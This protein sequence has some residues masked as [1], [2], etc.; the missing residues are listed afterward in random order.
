MSAFTEEERRY[1]LEEYENGTKIRVIAD[2]L[3][4]LYQTVRSAVHSKWYKEMKAEVGE[5][6]KQVEEPEVEVEENE[7]NNGS[8]N[9]VSDDVDEGV[10]EVTEEEVT[11]VT[12]EVTPEHDQES[13]DETEDEDEEMIDEL[14][15][16]NNIPAEVAEMMDYEAVDEAFTE[17]PMDS[18]IPF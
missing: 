13:E 5:F 3:G 17:E 2:E 18:V 14:G 15:E 9:L 11:E 10:T 16:V 12:E 7:S 6:E 8:S 1:I 4:R